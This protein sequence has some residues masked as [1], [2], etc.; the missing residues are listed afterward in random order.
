M[1][2]RLASDVAVVGGGLAGLA[3]A[4]YLAR[5]GRTVALFEQARELGGRAQTQTNHGFQFNVGPHALYQ[6]GAGAKVLQELGVAYSGGVPG[7]G[8]YALR[9]GRL[10]PFPASPL[11]LLTSGMLSPGDKL[12]AARL[13]AGLGRLDPAPLRSVTVRQWLE[14]TFARPRV[15]DL[16][17]TVVRIATYSNDPDRA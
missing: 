1:Q 15:R 2:E 17:Q 6:T 4:T 3:A 16:L 10:Y 9:D 7:A 12:A 13:L 11:A 5:A 14:R 8:S